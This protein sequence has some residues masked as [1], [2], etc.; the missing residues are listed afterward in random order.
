[1]H[2]MDERVEG[3]FITPMD[4]EDILTLA[5]R[6]DDVIDLIDGTAWR[7][8]MFHLGGPAPEP[9]RRMADVLRNSTAE[10]AQA[11]RDL[12]RGKS[13]AMHLRSVKQL[14]EE[15]DALYHDAVAALFAGGQNPLDVIK[16]KELY[17]RLEEAT[18]ECQHTAE[19]VQSVAL[20]YG[21]FVRGG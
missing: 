7:V 10:L 9:A 21:G 12:R 11:V 17:D 1:M 3:A 8:S 6:L 4:R 16:L 19:L 13:L 20:K 15:G 18:D 5:H 14:E 2:E